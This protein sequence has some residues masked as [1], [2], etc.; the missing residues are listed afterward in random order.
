MKLNTILDQIDMGSSAM[1][2]RKSLPDLP[3]V[4]FPTSPSS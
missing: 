1:W 3:D 4:R 2:K